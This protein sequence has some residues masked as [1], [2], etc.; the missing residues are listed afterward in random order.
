MSPSAD[1]RQRMGRLVEGWRDDHQAALECY[2]FEDWMG[3]GLGFLDIFEK[4]RAAWRVRSF[5][6][7]PQPDDRGETLRSLFAFWLTVAKLGESRGDQWSAKFAVGRL[8]EFKAAVQR[9]EG[10]L[11]SWDGPARS[12]LLGMRGSA[13]SDASAQV[14]SARDREA[15]TEGG[16]MASGEAPAANGR[17]EELSEEDFFADLAE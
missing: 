11:E 15:R 8:D 5:R 6:G 13:I 2:D 12:V 16:G 3:V 9:V 10:L 14:L 17:V 7:L 1:Y 4:A